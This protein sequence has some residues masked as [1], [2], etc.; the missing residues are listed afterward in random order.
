MVATTLGLAVPVATVGQD[1]PREAALGQMPQPGA[2]PDWLLDLEAWLSAVDSHQPGTADAAARAIAPWPSARLVTMLDDVV[3]LRDHMA[4]TRG[5]VH[6]KGRYLTARAIRRLLRI[7]ETERLGGELNRVLR[8]GAVL[9]A[10]IAIFARDLPLGRDASGIEVSMADGRQASAVPNE[11]YQLRFGREVLSK[12]RPAPATDPFAHA[13]YRATAAYLQR[14]RRLTLAEEQLRHARAVL[15]E[16]ADLLF[17]GAC[18]LETLASRRAQT[19]IRSLMLSDRYRLEIGSSAAL[20]RLA[21]ELFVRVLALEPG[22]GEARVRM[23]RLLG[24]RGR[25][26][27]AATEL[28]RALAVDLD[29]RIRYC[30][31]LFL[32]DEALAL[33]RGQQAV[34][35]YGRAAALA[36]GASS[37]LVAL[38]RQA[39][40]IG[41]RVATD[42][43]MRRWW[44]LRPDS[45]DPW[46]DYYFMQGEDVDV[47]LQEVYRTAG[48]ALR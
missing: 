21:L 29:A 26:E 38:A 25:H 22:R 42:E 35:A 31:W 30:A 37:P 39:R 19:E 45:S 10:D 48:E 33:H 47:R 3:G 5:E 20:E 17:R 9:H 41:D 12:L 40:E 7:T 23:A 34:T 43:A 36:P 15:S 44:A 4:V 24:Q 27:E 14:H 2:D 6:L 46:R 32:G 18:A 8:R 1:D 11:A 28:E 16:D 13:W